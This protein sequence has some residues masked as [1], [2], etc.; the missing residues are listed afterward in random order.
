MAIKKPAVITSAIVGGAMLS[1]MGL[2]AVSAQGQGQSDLVDKLAQKFN[3]NKSE[4]QKVFDEERAAHE[5][6]RKAKMKERLDQLVKD[7]KLTQDQA[8]KIVAKFEE[9]KTFR[10]SLK[11]K[12]AEERKAA[13]EQHRTE[14]EQWAKDNGI[15]LKY[16]RPHG[17]PGGPR[18]A[19]EGQM[20]EGN[21][22]SS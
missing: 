18:G 10:E 6:E 5:A 7:G 3:L 11:D 15:D 14:M 8:N 16:I 2:S 13:M 21:G 20:P 17:G 19:I 9:N 1:V 4:V 22:G 12:S